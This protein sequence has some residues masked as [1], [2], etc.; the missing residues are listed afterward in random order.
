MVILGHVI[1]VENASRSTT[2]TFKDTST[3]PFL[4]E[5]YSEL[6]KYCDKIY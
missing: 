2:D 6:V 4:A 3:I 5:N 1:N